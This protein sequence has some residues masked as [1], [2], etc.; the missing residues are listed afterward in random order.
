MSMMST[1]ERARRDLVIFR[2]MVT[3]LRFTPTG[4]DDDSVRER[5]ALRA[6]W[7]NAAGRIARLDEAAQRHELNPERVDELAAIARELTD[8][9]PELKARRYHLPDP[10]ALARAAGRPAAAQTT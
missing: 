9:L 7:N 3:R 4:D 6:E 1:D 2:D 8:L 10:A 5:M